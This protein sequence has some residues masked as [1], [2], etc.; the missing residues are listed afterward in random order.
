M[1]IFL[2]FENTITMDVAPETTVLQFRK[3]ICKKYDW[4]L[5]TIPSIGVISMAKV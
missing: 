3:D 1:Q 5:R 4:H 2:R